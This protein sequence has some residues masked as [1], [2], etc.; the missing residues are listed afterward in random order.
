MQKLLFIIAGFLLYGCS[1]DPV[2]NPVA[3]DVLFLVLGKMSIYNQMPNGEHQLRDHHFVAEIMPKEDGKILGG[4][5]TKQNDPAFE[6]TFKAEGSQFL[7]HGARLMNATVL[8]KEHPDGTYLF[9]YQT[10]NGEMKNQPV[11]LKRR[12]TTDIMPGP[13]TLSLSQNGQNVDPSGIDPNQDLT[14]SWTSMTGN[15]KMETSDIADLIFVLGFDCFGNNIAHSGRPYNGKPYLT[16]ED[17]SY[18]ILAAALNEGVNYQFIV[19]QATADATIYQGIPAIATYAT[20]T[21]LDVK[22]LG[23]AMQNNACPAK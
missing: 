10:A 12:I 22:T 17:N 20:L 11:S 3:D 1:N 9:S 6:L 14:I 8:H 2:H 23:T 4:T 18:T 7:A 13:E 21:F 15:M 16:Y 19:E 5:L